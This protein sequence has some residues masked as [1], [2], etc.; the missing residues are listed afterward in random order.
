MT[1]NIAICDDEI[2]ELEALSALLDLYKR[3][4]R[5]EIKIHSF[6]SG[7]SL[8]DAI[9]HGTCFD[10]IILDI[11]MPKENGIEIARELRKKQENIEIIF[12][13]SSPEYAVESYEVNANNYILKPLQKEKLFRVLTDCLNE[14]EKKLTAGFIIHSGPKQY[15]RILYSK[16]MYGEA[17]HKSVNLYLSDQTVVTS[18]MTFTELLKLLSSCPDFMQ[19]HRSYVVNMHYIEHIMKRNLI[20]TNGESIPIPKNNYDRVSKLFFDFAFSN[21]FEKEGI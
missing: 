8:L 6:R 16:L 11:I 12:L 17:M 5:A 18:V 14:M 21:S 7:F 20:L 2:T 1:I 19:P 3:E 4:N 10:I 9:D 13:T 15:T